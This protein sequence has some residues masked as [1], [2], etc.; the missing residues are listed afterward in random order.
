MS[1]HATTMPVVLHG[2]LR[3]LAGAAG[4]LWVRT[5]G[6]RRALHGGELLVGVQLCPAVAGCP[7]SACERHAVRL[8]AERDLG[9]V[10]ERAAAPQSGRRAPVRRVNWMGSVSALP[11]EAVSAEQVSGLPARCWC[12]AGGLPFYG[13]SVCSRPRLFC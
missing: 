12:I 1:G 9:P 10:S 13:V 7:W 6:Q 4:R 8:S 2:A 3:C 11:G 5:L